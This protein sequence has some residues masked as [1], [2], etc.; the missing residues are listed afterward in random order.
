[1]KGIT[2]WAKVVVLNFKENSCFVQNEGNGS[3]LGTKLTLKNQWFWIFS[4][5]LL[6]W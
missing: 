1:M 6:C 2:N 4:Q 3:F 5:N